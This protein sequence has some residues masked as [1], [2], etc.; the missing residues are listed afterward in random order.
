MGCHTHSGRTASAGCSSEAKE[1]DSAGFSGTLSN[2]TACAGC[3]SERGRPAGGAIPLGEE[4]PAQAVLQRPRKKP[5]LDVSSQIVPWCAGS[6]IILP[7]RRQPSL[8]VSSVTRKT[9]STGYPSMGHSQTSWGRLDLASQVRVGRPALSV[10]WAGKPDPVRIVS[11]W[12]LEVP[13][14]GG[15]P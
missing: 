15:Q 9:T 4:Q 1:G 8:A 5:A 10:T 7:Q 3:F 6:A 11:V 2:G 12:E 14:P 13:G